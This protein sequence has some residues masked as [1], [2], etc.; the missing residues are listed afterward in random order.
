VQAFAELIEGVSLA[1]KFYIF[2]LEVRK[3]G[4]P[5]IGV[6]LLRLAGIEN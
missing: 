2:Q 6:S 1:R 4:D 5:A 3:F